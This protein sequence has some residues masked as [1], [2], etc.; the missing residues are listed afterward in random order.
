MAGC[1]TLNDDDIPEYDKEETLRGPIGKKKQ[2]KRPSATEQWK[3]PY[4]KTFMANDEKRC[5][6]E[7][8]KTQLESYNLL[9]DNIL[10]EKN[11][12]R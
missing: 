2:N 9:L 6:V 4:F 7:L 5:K 12:G 8:M 1:S 10:L 3:E 11:L